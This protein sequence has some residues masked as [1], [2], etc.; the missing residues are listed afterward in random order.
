MSVIVRSSARLER[1]VAVGLH[2]A[3]TTGQSHVGHPCRNSR[4]F[5]RVPLLQPHQLRLLGDT[6]P[7]RASFVRCS[8]SRSLSSWPPPAATETK[9]PDTEMIARRKREN[10]H[11]SRNFR[12]QSIVIGNQPLTRQLF[13]RIIKILV[14]RPTII[15]SNTSLLLL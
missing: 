5:Y 8:S 9:R 14:C 12:F 2:Q 11:G 13:V 3:E 4:H 6:S 15:V 10:S 7:G 1:A